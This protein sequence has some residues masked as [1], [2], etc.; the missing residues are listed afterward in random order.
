[1]QLG[2]AARMQLYALA[3]QVQLGM[4]GAAAGWRMQQAAAPYPF[5][6]HPS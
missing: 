4:E 6:S 5:T 1:V 2:S 3:V